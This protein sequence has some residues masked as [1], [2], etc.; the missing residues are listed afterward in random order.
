M[1]DI[2]NIQRAGGN[3]LSVILFIY[4]FS[5]DQDFCGVSVFFPKSVWISFVLFSSCKKC[6]I[7]RSWHMEVNMRSSFCYSTA[8][9][10]FRT[11]VSCLLVTQF[12]T[13]TFG[14][15]IPLPVDPGHPKE[16]PQHS[17]LLCGCK[18]GWATFCR[19]RSLSPVLTGFAP[20][21]PIPCIV[22]TYL[23]MPWVRNDHRYTTRYLQFLVC[24]DTPLLLAVLL[25]VWLLQPLVR[26][27][28]LFCTF[29]INSVQCGGVLPQV[30]NHSQYQ[31]RP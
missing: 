27:Q 9:V 31:I 23:Q 24:V 13:R 17:W 8:V 21:S 30:Q 6:H 11:S 28:F 4:L 15:I 10:L 12:A 14:L 20:L 18:S 5:P 2:S 19:L 29:Q 3:C 7:T 1:K 25:L 26:V 16:C 22:N